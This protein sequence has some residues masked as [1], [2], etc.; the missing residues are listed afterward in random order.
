MPN[1][2]Q[3]LINF[4]LKSSVVAALVF[5]YIPIFTL[6]AFSFQEGRYLVLPF[7]GVTLKWYQTLVNHPEFFTAL[8]GSTV[9]AV[10]V[11]LIASVLGTCGAIVWMRYDFPGKR[12]FQV[13]TAL[14][15]VF[16]Q[17]L[18]GFV[19]LNWFSI[20]GNRFDFSMNAITVILGHLVYISPFVMVIVSVQLSSFDDELEDAA[21]DCGA[22]KLQVL[23]E[24]TLPLLWPGIFSAAIF[25]FLLSWGN[26]YLT[27]SLS[28]TTRTLPTFVFSGIA[29]GSSPAYP[30]LAALT[31]AVG[32]SLAYFAEFMRRRS[33]KY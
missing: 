18:L 9:I 16:P 1:R 3:K 33:L 13:I 4:G 26:F 8:A 7:E 5:L 24:V 22:S 32:L 23:R 25:A 30:A 2:G 19:M 6:V 14:P 12:I 31:F 15:L 28:G 29:T 21:R 20:L 17:L 10:F 11:T 27:Y